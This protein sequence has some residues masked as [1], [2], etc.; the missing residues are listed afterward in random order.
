[1]KRL[2]GKTALITGGSSGIGLATAQLFQRE[3]AKV[4]IAG[5]NKESVASGLAKLSPRTLGIVA[6]IES[7]KQIDNMIEK[8]GDDLGHIDML[9]LSAGI[10]RVAGFADL[11]ERDYRD[12]FDTNVK[13]LFFT[14]QRAM[15][16]LRKGGSI[17]LVSSGTIR[18]GRVGKS[19]YAASKAAVRSLTLSFAAE[20][21]EFGVRVNSV[22]PGP[23]ITPLQDSFAGRRIKDHLEAL[24]KVVPMGRM[25]RA[26][27]VAAA[28]LFLSS[29]ESSF[30]LGADIAVDGGW[31]Q[32][33]EVPPAIAARHEKPAKA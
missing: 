5:H 16:L 27:E 4:A 1:M 8:A 7:L 13:G 10:T 20:L 12:V 24:A 22:S 14:V 29:D 31:A 23:I 28:I 30:I 17:V 26:E 15:P 33:F 9:V 11:T 3:G 25:G 19:L 6:R 32:L 21:I 2:Q 18:M